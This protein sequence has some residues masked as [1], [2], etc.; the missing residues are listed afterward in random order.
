MAEAVPEVKAAL[1]EMAAAVAEVHLLY[2]FLQTEQ[3]ET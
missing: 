3:V 2:F 1:V